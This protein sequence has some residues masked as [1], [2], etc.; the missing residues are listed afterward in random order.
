MQPL[1]D[2]LL[3][4]LGGQRFGIA[5]ADVQ[6]IARVVRFAKLPK[7]PPVIE[8]VINFRG[9]AVPVLDIRARFRLPSKAVQPSDH[10]VI[11]RAGPRTVAIRVD[12][13]VDLLTVASGDIEDVAAVTSKSE[14]VA[15][16]VK[17]SDNIVLIHELATFLTAAEAADLDMASEQLQS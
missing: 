11:A 15:G 12:R 17:L 2:L 3:F 13:V 1:I 5:T 16:V 7:A 4:E 9:M 14:Y 6:E 10:L 8:G